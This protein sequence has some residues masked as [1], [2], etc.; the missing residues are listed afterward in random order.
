VPG[1]LWEQIEG[2]DGEKFEQFMMYLL[3]PRSERSIKGTWLRWNREHGIVAESDGP[4]STFY[5][6]TKERRWEERA[7]AYDRHEDQVLLRRLQER[8]L[9]SLVET[10][11]LGELLRKKALTAARMLSAVTQSIGQIEGREAVIMAVNLTPDQ[12][13]RMADIGTKIEQLALGNPTESMSITES[14]SAA[15]TENARS[16]L[17]KK[18]AEIKKRRMEADG[19]A[20]T[21]E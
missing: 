16:L 6:T 14:P 20:E 17:D 21:T 3:T 1:K 5:R 13:V 8:K 7:L 15:T 10:A 2:E 18:L 4:N 12:I 9:K 11:D 19:D